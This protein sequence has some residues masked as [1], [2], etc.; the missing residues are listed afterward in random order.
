MHELLTRLY[1]CTNPTLQVLIPH[2]LQ[3]AKKTYK[4]TFLRSIRH[5][6]QLTAMMA[7]SWQYCNSK[8]SPGRNQSGK[9]RIGGYWGSLQCLYH[10]QET[11]VPPK[12]L[13]GVGKQTVNV[14]ASANSWRILKYIDISEA[15]LWSRCQACIQL[16][17]I[18][19]ISFLSIRGK[20][21][22]DSTDKHSLHC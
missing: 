22:S 15:W 20:L 4:Q 11:C 21:A 19:V 13:H 18:S 9:P 8:S 7:S 16:A 10:R 2:G 17:Q 12:E 1:I 3:S 5:F 14:S 6:E